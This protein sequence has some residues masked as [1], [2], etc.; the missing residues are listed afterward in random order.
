MVAFF[1]DSHI[2]TSVHDTDI[3]TNMT[4]LKNNATLLGLQ[5]VLFGGDMTD[6]ADTKAAEQATFISA[7]GNLSAIPHLAA[8]GNHDYNAGTRVATTFNADFTQAYYTGK[9]WWDGGFYEAGHSE[10]SYL[11]RT[12]GGAD[13]IFLDLEYFPRD[14]VVAWADALLTTYASRTAIIMTHGY[15]Y[16]DNTPYTVGDSGAATGGDPEGA[17]YNLGDDMWSGL[18]SQH[19][20]VILVQSGHIWTTARHVANSDGGQPVNQ[21]LFNRQLHNDWNAT[22]MRF[23]IFNPSARTIKVQTFSPVAWAF[24]DDA[25]NQFT[26]SY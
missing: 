10:N 16:S 6:D 20:N 24:H 23:M 19:D 3:V 12:I 2:G 13:Y 15:E 25:D 21:V 4:Y 9:S 5:A 8:I 11:L 7:I 17:D 18:F 26:M 14:A 22:V 1:T